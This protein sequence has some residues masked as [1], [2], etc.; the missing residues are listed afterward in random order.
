MHTYSAGNQ[1]ILAGVASSGAFALPDTNL[2]AIVCT[3]ATALPVKLHQQCHCQCVW[4]SDMQSESAVPYIYQCTTSNLLWHGA[5][6]RPQAGSAAVAGEAHGQ[7]YS[8][9]T[10]S[11]HLGAGRHLHTHEAVPP[12]RG[13]LACRVCGAALQACYR[14]H[15]IQQNY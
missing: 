3:C 13:L 2:A 15:T 14:L 11:V 5:M 12:E 4:P 6:L 10:D 1:N 9:S 7:I 8:I